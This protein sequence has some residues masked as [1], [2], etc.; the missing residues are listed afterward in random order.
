[1]RVFASVIISNKGPRRSASLKRSASILFVLILACSF[2]H[3]AAATVS[4]QA[5]PKSS[6]PCSGTNGL[7]KGEIAE[8]LNIHNFFREGLRLKPLTWDC[9]LAD[10]A[11]AWA[12][13]GV[14]EHRDDTIY[15][16]SIFVAASSDVAAS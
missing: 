13:R 2:G 3:M 9:R 1:M 15:G 8:I 11:Q 7:T 10:L 14:P 16:E 12:K 5:A 4:A 6:A